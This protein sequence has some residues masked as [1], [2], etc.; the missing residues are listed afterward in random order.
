MEDEVV[1][2]VMTDTD[3]YRSQK[4]IEEK[5]KMIEKQTEERSS[6][7]CN[8]RKSL[9]DN[10][11]VDGKIKLEKKL[12]KEEIPHKILLD[13]EK[14]EIRDGKQMGSGEPTNRYFILS[15]NDA[16]SILDARLD[17]VCFFFCFFDLFPLRIL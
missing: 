17:K 7:T 13:K 9:N 6:S 5:R 14:L 1:K 10:I 8:K 16:E 12:K 11:A 2:K 4:L 3:T 15:T